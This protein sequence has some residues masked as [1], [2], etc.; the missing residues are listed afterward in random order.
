[1]MTINE[2]LMQKEIDELVPIIN[3][4]DG[5]LTELETFYDNDINDGNDVLYPIINDLKFQIESLQE[6]KNNLE[7]ILES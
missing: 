4:L 7:R 6:T 5:I 3:N 1:M 2:Q